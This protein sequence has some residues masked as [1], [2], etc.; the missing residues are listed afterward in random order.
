MP[1]RKA[2]LVSQFL[3]G[4]S[5]E[6]IEEYQDFFREVA[7]R[8]NGVY[9]LYKGK[10][11]YYVG[12]ATNLGA[13]LKQH[14]RNRHGGQW[15]RFSIY[16]TIGDNHIRELEALVLRIVHPKGNR[17]I[18]KFPQAENLRR[19]FTGQVRQES[20]RR[21]DAL[22]GRETKRASKTLR[23]PVNRDT[24]APILGKFANRPRFLRATY[25]GRTYRA[26][27]RPD[28]SILYAKETY[29]SPSGAARAVINPQRTRA[30][31]GWWFWYYERAPGDWVRLN[32]I[33]R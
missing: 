16:L 6:A 13:R 11:L 20:Q 26:R 29:R 30:V 10:R 3:E 1:K 12:L 32:E 4:I 9:A 2:T 24:G 19:T 7:R 25:K 17:Q 28:G 22:L 27:V 15:D 18:G 23:K 5:G 14:L 33:R 31:S 21:L 8:R